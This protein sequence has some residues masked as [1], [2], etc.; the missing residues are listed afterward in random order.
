MMYQNTNDY[1]FDSSKFEKH[2]PLSPTPYERG[3]AE[4]V[5]YHRK[6]KG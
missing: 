5:E 4:T 3:I 6:L 1:L 2:F